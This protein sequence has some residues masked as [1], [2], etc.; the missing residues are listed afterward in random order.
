VISNR[1]IWCGCQK[2]KGE[3]VVQPRE[4]KAQPSGAQSGELESAVGEKEKERDVRRM[5]KIIRGYPREVA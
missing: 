1:Q 3:E 2:K 4:A 5:F